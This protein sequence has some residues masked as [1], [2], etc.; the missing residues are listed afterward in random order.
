MLWKPQER[1]HDSGYWASQ[2]I[3][4]YAPPAPPEPEDPVLCFDGGRVPLRAG[5]EPRLLQVWDFPEQSRFVYRFTLDDTR[6]F[7]PVGFRGRTDPTG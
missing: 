4:Q 2:A 5:E 3:N 7:L 6:F 1:C